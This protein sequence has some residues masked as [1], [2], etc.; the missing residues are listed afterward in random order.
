[1]LD[2]FTEGQCVWGRVWL[3]LSPL[4]VPTLSSSTQCLGKGVGADPLAFCIRARK[5]C[6]QL[7]KADGPNSSPPFEYWWVGIVVKLIF[8]WKRCSLPCFATSLRAQLAIKMT[9]HSQP[10]WLPVM[11]AWEPTLVLSHCVAVSVCSGCWEHALVFAK[12]AAVF[13][14]PSFPFI[15][16]FPIIF[17]WECELLKLITQR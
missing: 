1:M 16:L 17:R 4:W 12:G 7:Q 14:A 5:N 2:E 11:P 15:V 3:L 9:P 8:P 10:L 13:S 6:V